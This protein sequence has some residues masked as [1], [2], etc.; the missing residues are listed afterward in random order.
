MMYTAEQ[1]ANVA[2]TIGELQ[3]KLLIEKS[4]TTTQQREIDSLK[5]HIKNLEN[6]LAEKRYD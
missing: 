1:M 4:I 3:A 5:E 6:Q 2:V